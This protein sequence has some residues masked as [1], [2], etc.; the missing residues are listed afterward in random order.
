MNRTSPLPPSAA[1]DE[2]DL[3]ELFHAIWRQKK[4]VIGCTLLAGVLGAGYAFL[5]PKTYEV[6]S[7]LRPAAINELDA[8]NRSEVYKLPPADALLKVG[9]QLDSY[10]ARL[11]FFKDHEEL[12]KAFKKPGQSLEQSF[13][14]FN[15]NSVNLILPDPKKSDSLSNYIRLELQY[16]ADV[17]GV[18]ILNGFVDY[19][20]A[21]ERQQV[22]A[23]LKVIVNNRLTELKGKIDAAR[24]NYDTDKESKIA[25]LLEAD[26]LKRAQLQ[27]EL[28]ALRLQ[29]K[30]ERTN[31]LAELAEAIS[32]AKSMGIRTP[33]TP[34]SMADATRSSG[35]VM[36]TEVNNQKIPLYFMGTEALEAERAAL[37]QRTSDDFTNPRIAEIGKEL[38]LLE[39]NREVEVL[40]KRGNED[41]FLQDVE[42]L[43][44]EVARLR[45]LN[46]DMSNLKLV[47]IDRRAQ[48]PLSPVKPKKPL[49]IALS[50]V[51]GLLLGLMIALIRYFIRSRSQ[52]LPY[53][54]LGD[55]S[56][57]RR[58][59]KDE[60]L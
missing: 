11:G 35:Q 19:A 37:Q 40:R 17:D 10:E 12:F 49:V 22:G 21:A 27:D 55:S 45:G 28:S 47:T 57:A 25:K 13:E 51:G 7:V 16:P 4:L 6:S 39:S 42:P 34:S 20:I 33:T 56:F 60:S 2:I 48:E 8:L 5:A 58:E 30:M 32:I 15:R 14:E 44:A 38:Q 41:I 59:G 46:I 1:S 50:L 18:A 3:F 23:D 43:R 52:A 53:T 31:R 24:S 36:R 54:A 26:R 9:A 29:M